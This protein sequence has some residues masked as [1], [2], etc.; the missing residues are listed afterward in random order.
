[1]KIITTLVCLFVLNLGHS[2][3]VPSSNNPPPA[4]M[5]PTKKE[6]PSKVYS[7]VEIEPRFTEWRTFLQQNLR[8]PDTCTKTGTQGLVMMSFVVEKD[9]RLTNIKVHESSPQKNKFLVAESIRVLKLTDT[10]WLAG[11]YNNE[12]VRTYHLQSIAFVIPDEE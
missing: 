8:Y 10:K 6:D 12:K 2:Q 4:P 7:R 5:E 3:D 11:I 9:G 1:M